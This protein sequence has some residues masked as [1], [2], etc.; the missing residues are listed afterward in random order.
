MID[1]NSETWIECQRWRDRWEDVEKLRGGGQG[2]AYR[3]LRT[4]D[5]QVAFLK[6]IKAKRDPE[7]RARFFREAAAY[8]TVRTPGVPRLIES[9]A[10][11][12]GKGEV[13][14]YIATSFIE[15][16]TMREWREAQQSVDLHVALESTMALLKTL[17]ECHRGG[18]LHRDIKPDNVILANGDPAWPVLLDFG[19]NFHPD[20][21][22]DFET[23]AGQEIGNRFLRLPE[24]SAGS[25]VKQDSRSDLSFCAGI[26]FYLLTGANPDLLQDA[27]GRLPHQRSGTLAKLEQI[28]GAGLGRLLALFDSGFAPQIA[29][30]FNNVD[31]MI[32]SMVK[33]MDRHQPVGN[34]EDDLTAIREMMDTVA[35][36]RQAARYERLSEALREIQR[37]HEDTRRSLG[38]AMNWRQSGHHVSAESGRNTLGWVRPGSEEE[39]LSVKC[40]VREVGGEIV[41]H[42]S[43]EPVFRTATESP[44]YGAKFDETIRT[45]LL[46]RLREAVSGRGVLPPEADEFGERRPFAELTEARD[47][48]RR[49][50]RHVIAFVFDPAQE[51]RGKLRYCLGN[52][53]ENRKTRETL[54]AAFVVALV[55]LSQVAAVS[56]VLEGE[57]MESSRWVV[58][59]ADLEPEEQAV[60]YANAQEGERIAFELARRFGSQP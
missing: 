1:G 3:A 52:F 37:V 23:E 56:N 26:C 47:E 39:V 2:E 33:V 35:S 15:G 13:D 32:D 5:R 46:A 59:S 11:L 20:R 44:R 50:G 38:F 18:L 40:E 14:P 43:G 57:S 53:L 12:H 22:V 27:E 48:A 30:R 42:L 9:N 17:R 4:S 51:Q 28:A 19:L 24:L 6:V 16:P 55:P 45:W 36:Q 29:D 54:A 41:I 34:A 10:H 60:I 49:T 7:R 21:T 31:A 25:R 8:D 58:F